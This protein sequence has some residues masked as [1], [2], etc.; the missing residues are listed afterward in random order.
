MK[1]R[2]WIIC[3]VTGIIL[4]AILAYYTGRSSIKIQPEY[5]FFAQIEEISESYF[6]IKG[7]DINDINH[8]GEYTIKLDDNTKLEWCGTEIT[9]SDLQKGDYISVTYVGNIQET[10]PAHI[11][12]PIVEILLLENP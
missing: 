11:E 5:T 7:L 8:R 3:C 1:T 10:N 2:A 6:L 9:S 12:E 4:T